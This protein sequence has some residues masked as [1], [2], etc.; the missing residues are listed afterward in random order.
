MG[1]GC[2]GGRRGGMARVVEVGSAAVAVASVGPAEPSGLSGVDR[3][4][5]TSSRYITLL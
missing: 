5:D 1:K 2:K 4:I 3:Q